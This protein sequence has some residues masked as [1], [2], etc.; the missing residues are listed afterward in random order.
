VVVVSV[1]VRRA[2]RGRGE[3]WRPCLWNRCFCR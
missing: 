2:C 3:D 1:D